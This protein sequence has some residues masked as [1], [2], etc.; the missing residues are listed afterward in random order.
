MEVKTQEAT[1][2]EG[3][4]VLNL[5]RKTDEHKVG[6]WGKLEFFQWD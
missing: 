3:Y 6:V 4:L 1:R 5:I 2:V